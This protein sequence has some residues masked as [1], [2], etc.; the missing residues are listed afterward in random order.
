MATGSRRP[1]LL[2]PWL[3]SSR[4]SVNH[5]AVTCGRRRVYQQRVIAVQVQGSWSR[6]RPGA[7]LSQGIEVP[8]ISAGAAAPVL[9][10]SR[11]LGGG[12]VP[13]RPLAR[14]RGWN[15]TPAVG[16]FASFPRA[17]F[18]VHK[19]LFQPSILKTAME[20]NTV[21]LTSQINKQVKMG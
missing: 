21:I 6:R 5:S 11:T 13:R 8:G 9:A 17:L 12:T 15:S 19:A 14:Q 10:V 1:A 20:A 2:C 7:G 3:I 16:L 18:T 4:L